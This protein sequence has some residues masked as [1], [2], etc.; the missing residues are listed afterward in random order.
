MLIARYLR[1]KQTFFINK[2]EK[3]C[4]QAQIKSNLKS[5]QN[6]IKQFKLWMQFK[7]INK[8]IAFQ[9]EEIQALDHIWNYYLGAYF[10][11]YIVEICY[12]SF[13]FILPM[14]KNVQ[15]VENVQLTL[16]IFSLQF[17]FILLWITYE[18][19]QIAHKNENLRT[20]QC[21]F[22]KILIE[23]K[24]RLQF[25]D[26]LMVTICFFYFVIIIVF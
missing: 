4:K 12:L 17:F 8:K 6:E 20:K 3:I 7:S 15:L 9:Y 23:F 10:Y 13:S 19:V 11:G 5:N 14:I 16:I 25:K 21:K 2:L 24:Y 26:I 1:I 22:M 18:C